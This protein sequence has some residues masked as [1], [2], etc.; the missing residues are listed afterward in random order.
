[1]SRYSRRLVNTVEEW[2]RVIEA[3]AR[4]PDLEKAVAAARS[5]GPPR[6]VASSDQV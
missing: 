6:F 4:V 1:M 3:A 2:E 5:G